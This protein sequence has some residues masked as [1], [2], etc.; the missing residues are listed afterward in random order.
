VSQRSPVNETHRAQAIGELVAAARVQ[1]AEGTP[2][3]DDAELESSHPELM[4][5]LGCAFAKLRLI[6]RAQQMAGE[7]SGESSRGSDLEPASFENDEPATPADDDTFSFHGLPFSGDFSEYR[8][9]ADGMPAAGLRQFGDYYLLKELG[10]GG[11]GV[12]YEAEQLSLNRKVALKMI[13]AG[14]MASE[15]DIVRFHTEAEAAAQLDHPNVLK[16]F[17]IGEWE[18]CHF[19][20]MA[21]VRGRNLAEE[22]RDQLLSSQQAAGYLV[23]L[24][25]AIS[26]AHRQQVLHRD[27]KPSNVLIDHHGEVYVTDFGLAKRLDV[28]TSLTATGH[29]L[30]TPA[31]MS[32]EQAAADDDEIGPASDIYSLGA[33]LYFLLVG[34]PPF[35]SDTAAKT[36]MQ[37]VNQEPVA[38]R[39]LNPAVDR[40]LETIC[41]KCLEKD[42]HRRYRSA[43]D[44]AADLQRYLAGE[45][46]QARPIRLLGRA[47]RWGG[48]NPAQ[49]MLMLLI[50]F[51]ISAGSVGGFAYINRANEFKRQIAEQ[52]LGQQLADARRR[53]ELARREAAEQV[54]ETQTYVARLNQVRNLR[55]DPVAGW[56]WN[57]LDTLALAAGQD[58]PVRDVLE[59][60]NETIRCLAATD[61]REVERWE[62]SSRPYCVAFNQE[63]NQIA[64]GFYKARVTCEVTLIDLDGTQTHLNYPASVTWQFNHGGKQDGVY[65]IA[66]SPDG[67]WLLAGLRSGTIL[68]WKLTGSPAAAPDLIWQLGDRSIQDIGFHRESHDLY[69]LGAELYRWS[70]EALDEDNSTP[71]ATLSL[72]APE[73]YH[74]SVGDESVVLSRYG[75]GRLLDLHDLHEIG[76]FSGSNPAW[77]PNGR[78][79]GAVRND[80]ISL[81]DATSQ[82]SARLLSDPDQKYERLYFSADGTALISLSERGELQ[83]WN[84]TSGEP[85]IQLTIG[86]D[87]VKAAVS[88]A[89]NHLAV[90]GPRD[91][92]LF[93]FRGFSE[94]PVSTTIAHGVWPLRSFSLSADGDK[95]VTLGQVSGDG[96]VEIS[97]HTIGAGGPVATIRRARSSLETLAVQHQP[98]GDLIAQAWGVEEVLRLDD[99]ATGDAVSTPAAHM[100]TDLFRF[101]PD[102]ER[103][104]AAGYL[105]EGAPYHRLE[106]YDF[107]KS[108]K[109]PETMPIQL[110]PLYLNQ[111]SGS[112]PLGSLDV[113]RKWVL[114]G[115]ESGRLFFFR[116][117][118]GEYLPKLTLDHA[119]RTDITSVAIH[120]SETFAVVGELN[121]KLHRIELPS[122]KLLEN[123]P[124]H[125]R[126]VEAIRF[127]PDGRLMATASRDR[128]VR[129][130][131][132]EG[133]SWMQVLELPHSGP[134]Q[135]VEFA[136]QGESLVSLADREHGLRVW[137][138][139]RI[140]ATFSKLG[141]AW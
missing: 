100:R 57:A 77:A 80:G 30:G 128:T 21:F 86:G 49:A 33:V 111:L 135:A 40:D 43:A 75:K 55:N 69:A 96:T 109:S 66:Y 10:R 20:S 123:L 62:F 81:V 36:M 7:G 44:L 102:G 17:E 67:R 35:Q 120:P 98:G 37:V 41:L 87:E 22:V 85:V 23:K 8:F 93:E 73:G 137:D 101:T 29:V 141:I 42:P 103:L 50:A 125:Y 70:G 39:R 122:G 47:I 28:D 99:F 97:A 56:T 136:K 90:I 113:S 59:L 83:L 84:L 78:C 45:P 129:L 46:I 91:A 9:D 112:Q 19:F 48:R 64:V 54:A 18:G 25:K 34:R 14:S 63:G 139:S 4:P 24:A 117:E 119:F 106:A 76:E 58:V 16:I 126:S 5:E 110:D 130:W 89:G 32:P 12:V 53:E 65:S 2:L 15:A 13:L 61:L 74:F 104:W 115:G 131:R 140:E 107:S 1:I 38:P 138:L 26:H 105:R 121:G 11:M 27:L 88:P 71:A 51:S 92:R 127:T 68:G 31:F 82:Q 108:L 72:D 6:A 134:V 116:Q 118:T 95:I 52:T 79:F 94:K 124:P 114:A 132:Q 60:R 133:D 3:P